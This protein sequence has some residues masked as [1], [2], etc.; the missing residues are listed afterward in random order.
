[1]VKLIHYIFRN[2]YY[3]EVLKAYKEATE[4]LSQ[5]YGLWLGT[6]THQL[7]ENYKSKIF[8]YNNLNSI[9]SIQS[10]ISETNYL[11]RYEK[12]AVRWL[13]KEIYDFTDIPIINLNEYQFI[14]ENKYKILT[15]ASILKQY[16]SLYTHHKEAVDRFLNYPSYNIKFNQIRK[17]VDSESSIKHISCVLTTV[18]KCMRENPKAWDLYAQGR[19]ISIIP[20]PELESINPDYFSSKELFL[21][22]WSNHKKLISLLLGD[23]NY[24]ICSFEKEAIEKEED[25]CFYVASRNMKKIDTDKINIQLEDEKELK[26]VILN[27]RL[28]GSK[29]NFVESFTLSKFY[30]LRADFDKIGIPFDE[31]VKKIKNNEEAIKSYNQITSGKSKVFIEDYLRSVKEGSHLYNYIETFKAEKGKRDEAKLIQRNYSD[32]FSSLFCD[33]NL[34]TCSLEEIKVVLDSKKRIE[35][36]DGS[37]KDLKRKLEEVKRKRELEERKKQERQEL[38]NGVS[39]WMQPRRSTVHCFSLYY[40]YPVN[41]SWSASEEEWDI[42]N[43]IWDFKANPNRPQ[44]ESEIKRRHEEA[45]EEIMPD[46]KKVLNHFFGNNKRN[47]T[48]VCIPSSKKIVTERRYKEFSKR[49]CN[50]TGMINGYDYITIVKDG[51]SKRDPQNTTGYSIQPEISIDE[52]FFR[53]RL[54]VLFDDVITTGSSMERLK[55]LLESAG[56]TVLGGLSIGKTKHERQPS[57]PIESL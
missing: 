35:I 56:A 47:L 24:N 57:N 29:C 5:A 45:L 39:T 54:I 55:R 43:L 31:A 37:I 14:A 7:G 3:K 33:L 42:R 4:K 28:Y 21:G 20:L 10:W 23:D 13:Y 48:L 41:C 1:M 26:R 52:T 18:K 2:T 17:V 9:R 36:R 8:V 12:D 16:K 11:L 51:M 25:I 44:S 32:G 49:L 50:E 46:L 27:S 15:Y 6:I 30:S 19:S 53:E 22:Y 38:I 40:Y 34:D